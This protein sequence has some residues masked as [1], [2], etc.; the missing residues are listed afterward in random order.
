MRNPV[1][2]PLSVKLWSQASTIARDQLP[3]ATP[4]ERY[5]RTCNLYIWLGGSWI[6]NRDG[7]TW[8]S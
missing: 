4:E 3:D 2:R 7:W 6:V 5:A 8:H 1:L